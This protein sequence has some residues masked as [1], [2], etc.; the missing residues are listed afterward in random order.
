MGTEG[1]WASGRVG[2]SR[3]LLGCSLLKAERGS[4]SL[5]SC[6]AFDLAPISKTISSLD[7]SG[8][9]SPQARSTLGMRST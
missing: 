1:P 3:L 9:L 7:M 2:P 8:V 4:F 6:T 5:S